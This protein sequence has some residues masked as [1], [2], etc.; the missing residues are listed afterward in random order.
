VANGLLAFALVALFVS[1]FIIN[2]TFAILASQRLRELGL[3]RAMGGSTR[4][5]RVIMFVM[6]V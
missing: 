1:G 4:Q 5:V 3:L 6:R 2:N